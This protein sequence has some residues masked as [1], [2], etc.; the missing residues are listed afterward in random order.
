MLRGCLFTIDGRSL[1]C[2]NLLRLRVF[3]CLF[4]LF[5]EVKAAIMYPMKGT[6]FSHGRCTASNVTI[7]S[8]K[9]MLNTLGGA[10]IGQ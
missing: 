10:V 2:K 6:N 3:F 1:Q 7:E 4:E 9:Y 5:Q 8:Y